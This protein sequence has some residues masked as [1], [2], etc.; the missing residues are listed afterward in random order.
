MP[1][2]LRSPLNS[3]PEYITQLLMTSVLFSR[4]EAFLNEDEVGEDISSLKKPFNPST[5]DSRSGLSIQDGSF[6][7]NE[8]RTSKIDSDSTGGSTSGSS[9]L[10]DNTDQRFQLK[11]IDVTFP[12][13]VLTLVTGATASGKTALLVCLIVSFL[14]CDLTDIFVL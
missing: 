14:R 5:G 12:D 10:G 8:V 2:Y 6:I 9:A 4:I 13:G 7:W 1:V 11:N 3:F